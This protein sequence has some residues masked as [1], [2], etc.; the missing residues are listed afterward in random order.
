MKQ[1]RLRM[2][3]LPGARLLPQL[4]RG[5][6]VLLT[7]GVASAACAPFAPESEAISGCKVTDGDTIRCGDER[8]RL[9]GIDTAEMPGHCRQGRDCVEGDPFAAKRSLEHLIAGRELTIQRAGQDRYR[10]TLATVQADGEDLSCRQLGRG[11]AIY[12]ADWDDGGLVA[13]T[14]PDLT[15]AS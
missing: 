7:V 5:I 2:R 10:R 15:A 11:H 13:A 6:L 4:A 3:K 12:R 9:L 14:C 1:N 8:V